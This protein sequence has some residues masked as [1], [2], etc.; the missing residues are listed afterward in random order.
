[1][2]FASASMAESLDVSQAY[3]NVEKSLE[4]TSAR[5][6]GLPMT[7]Y[8]TGDNNFRYNIFPEYK[9]NRRKQPRPTH[10]QAV[11]LYLADKHAAVISDGCEADDLCGIDQTQSNA[12]GEDTIL[13]SIDKDL[14]Q[15][16]GKHY[17]PAI[18]R[19]GVEISPEREYYVTPNDGLRFFYWQLL[20]GDAGDGV[21]GA[22][23]I[24]KVKAERILEGL[25]NELELF[26]AV[27]DYFSCEEELLL[28]GQ[29]LW[30]WRAPEGIWKLPNQES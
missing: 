9:L 16:P 12:Q 11:K 1:M 4:Q 5:L 28:N 18:W 25:S 14:D 15:I 7:L 19:D 29:V 13:C 3:Y 10:L 2:A 22:K 27:S 6:N 21:K 8:L 24:G 30:I 17:R 20:V 23:G 26:E